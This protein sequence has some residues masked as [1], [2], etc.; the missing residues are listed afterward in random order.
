MIKFADESGSINYCF[1]AVF[2]SCTVMYSFLGRRC[3][4]TFW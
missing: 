1:C 4:C 3:V 2:V